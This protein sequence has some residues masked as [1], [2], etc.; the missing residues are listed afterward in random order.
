M[1]ARFRG[2]LLQLDGALEEPLR[3]LA[4]VRLEVRLRPQAPHQQDGVVR[5]LG[6]PR[7]LAG[8]G[9]RLGDARRASRTRSRGGLPRP[10]TRRHRPLRHAPARRDEGPRASR[11]ACLR[12]GREPTRAR[13]RRQ[14]ARETVEQLPA[15]ID[16]ACHEELARG[17]A[18]AAIRLRR[19]RVRREPSG[20]LG[21]F[22]CDLRRAAARCPPGG[23][24]EQRRRLVARPVRAEGKVVRTLLQVAGDL[25]EPQMEPSTLA[26]G[27]HRE[28]AACEQRVLGPNVLALEADD[29]GLFGRPQRVRGVVGERLQH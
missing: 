26:G 1:G 17:E 22:S 3:D 20:V 8:E 13:A 2:R 16:V 12:R 6:D 18:P 9:E 7:R 23:L 25:S 21:D 29:A 14:L 19:A 11:G 10:G 24:L 28:R 5:A 4:G 15:A 27:Q